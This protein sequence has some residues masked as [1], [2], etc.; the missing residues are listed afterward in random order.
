[1][2]GKYFAVLFISLYITICDGSTSP[3]KFPQCNQPLHKDRMQV[4]RGENATLRLRLLM[5]GA[6]STTGKGT[7]FTWA[8]D[9]RENTLQTYHKEKAGV[10]EINGFNTIIH[11]SDRRKNVIS[12][13]AWQGLC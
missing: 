5:F 13:A 2:P 3:L 1:M 12:L 6:T 11:G 10:A 4:N 8:R 9:R 7:L